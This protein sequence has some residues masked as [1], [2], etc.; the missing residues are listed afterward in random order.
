[1]SFSIQHFC[2][3]YETGQIETVIFEQLPD[4]YLVRISLTLSSY[5]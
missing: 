1:M 5:N 4:D 3:T 2:E